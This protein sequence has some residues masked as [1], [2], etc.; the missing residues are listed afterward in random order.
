MLVYLVKYILHFIVNKIPLEASLYF[1]TRGRRWRQHIYIALRMRQLQ[2]QPFS[3]TRRDVLWLRS[4]HLDH[5]VHQASSS[6]SFL[7]ILRPG[8]SEHHLWSRLPAAFQRIS[9]TVAHHETILD[10]TTSCLHTKLTRKYQP[11]PL[12]VTNLI[13]PRDIWLETF[14]PTQHANRM[15]CDW[16][17]YIV[18][19]RHCDCTIGGLNMEPSDNCNFTNATWNGPE[20]NRDAFHL[21][22]YPC[23]CTHG[24]CAKKSCR[25][26][27]VLEYSV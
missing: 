13:N 19:K 1:E 26:E 27:F 12:N 20:V 23:P 8:S 6:S 18:K 22:I 24:G 7:S 3:L 17:V 21:L 11:R 4:V 9:S 15:S 10:H 14:S 25:A 16:Y 2:H 5:A